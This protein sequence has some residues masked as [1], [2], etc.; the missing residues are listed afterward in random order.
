MY[1]MYVVYTRAAHQRANATHKH[2]QYIYLVLETHAFKRKN[3]RLILEIIIHVLRY[4]GLQLRLC[5]IYILTICTI[6]MQIYLTSLVNK[7]QKCY[8][9]KKKILCHYPLYFVDDA[10][11]M[12]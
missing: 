7:M 5:H 4:C 9:W 10:S 11:L 8:F 12:H 6:I 2:I 3:K 1:I